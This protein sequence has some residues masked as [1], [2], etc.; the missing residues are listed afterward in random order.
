MDLDIKKFWKAIAE[1]DA[2]K[3]ALILIKPQLSDGI[4]QMSNLL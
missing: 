4:I 3:Y 2:E 1:Q